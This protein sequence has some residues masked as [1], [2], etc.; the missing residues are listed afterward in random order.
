M[1]KI[2]ADILALLISSLAHGQVLSK[3]PGVTYSGPPTYTREFPE[4]FRDNGG[5]LSPFGSHI[6][7]KAEVEGK[8]FAGVLHFAC[9]TGQNVLDY[10]RTGLFGQS[11]VGRLYFRYA[12]QRSE[13]CYGLGS[14]N[15]CPRQS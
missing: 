5:P 14:G 6:G 15:T 3:V 10:S 11:S 1:K 7:L 9:A 13:L 2:L 8:A 12:A 4:A